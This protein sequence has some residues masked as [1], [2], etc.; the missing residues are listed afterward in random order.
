MGFLDKLLGRE[1]MTQQRQGPAYGQQGPAYGQ[2]SGPASGPQDSMTGATSQDRQAVARYRYLLR[3]APPEKIEEAHAQAFAQLTTEQ[4]RQVLEEMT[5]TL[6]A[7]EQPQSDDPQQ[8]AR[9]ATRAEMRSPGYLQST[10]GGRGFAGGGGMMGGFGGS[11]LGTIAGVV[12]G[13]AVADTLLG[14]FD[15]SPDQQQAVGD[16][17]DTSGT[18]DAGSGDAGSGD[19]GSADP[20]SAD[21]ASYD[22]GG[23]DTAGTDAGW[24]GDQ[25]GFG[26]AGGDF[27]GGDFF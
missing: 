15:S 11:L 14:G 13:T 1:P 7:G 20:G 9:A 5:Q 25:S 3:T 22:A 17:G 23:S 10:F 26:D 21:Q 16:T 2:D 27:G 24:G 18:G 8:L 4:R 12:I 19:A 6:P